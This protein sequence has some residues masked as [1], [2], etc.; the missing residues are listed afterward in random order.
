MEKK[1][2]QAL[3]YLFHPLL[4]PT[5]AVLILMF[6]PDNNF[7]ALP[8]QSL[9]LLFAFV[10]LSTFVF[11]ALLI[12]ILKNFKIIPNLQMDE[13]QSRIFPLMIM[14]MT[15]YAVFYLLKQGPFDT[16]FNMFMLGSTLLVLFSLLVNYFWKISLH[17]VAL[18]GLSG[19]LLG[20]AI[21]FGIELRP[22]IFLIILIAGTTAFS[23][24]KLNAH[25]PSEVYAGFI[26][27]AGVMAALFLAV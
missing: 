2:A 14:S 11:P 15:Y 27:G 23:R 20:M 19:A 17:L 3:S 18:G 25:S 12:L 26:L 21:R 16:V 24:L 6:L 1:F 4:I 22:I 10:F 8:F 13:K 7:V 5:Y 9:L